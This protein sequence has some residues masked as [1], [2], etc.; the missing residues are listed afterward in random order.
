MTGWC[1][2]AVGPGAGTFRLSGQG[3]LDGANDGLAAGGDM[4]M[5]D[6]HLLLALA[7][8]RVQGPEQPGSKAKQTICL[9][10]GAARI[11]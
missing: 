3:G 11:G 5:F 4:H 2:S 6:R 8:V 10:C 9:K 7:A 1:S